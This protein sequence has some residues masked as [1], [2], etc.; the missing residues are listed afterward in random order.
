MYIFI[1]VIECCFITSKHALCANFDDENNPHLRS[2][3]VNYGTAFQPN[4][5]NHLNEY[6]V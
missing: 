4:I 6:T 2:Q 5:T 3:T 1:C